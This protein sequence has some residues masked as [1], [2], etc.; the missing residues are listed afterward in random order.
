MRGLVATWFVM[1]SLGYVCL[2]GLAGDAAK[3]SRETARFIAAATA[4]GM[5]V[6]AQVATQ[7]EKAL[8]N[9]KRL[10]TAD[11]PKHFESP[12]FLLYGTLPGKDL[13]DVAPGLEKQYELALKTLEM[14]SEETWPGKMAVYFF[15]ER[16]PFNSFVRVVEKRKIEEDEAGSFDIEGEE[17]HAI[18]GPS[19]NKADV[20]VVG[21]AGVQ[22]AGALLTKKTRG[23]RVPSWII[24]SFGRATI[25][26]AGSVKELSAEHRRAQA[27]AL[28][29]KT[30]KSAF[31][32]GVTGEEATILQTSAIEYLVYSGK[33]S[34][35]FPIMQGFKPTEQME[36]PTLDAALMSANLSVDRL[37][38]VWQA[39]VK[40]VK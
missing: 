25:F 10:Y 30:L 40:T 3:N 16:R 28:K 36:E 26:R 22:V 32:S 21:Q 11:T 27:L 18:V 20:N 4:R 29:K 33:S 17:P 34:K 24:S 5:T 14:E 1:V 35:F 2:D 7:H 15:S 6:P 8:V 9:W 13:K 37:D 12:H 23:A 31:S 38:Q 39:W 19:E